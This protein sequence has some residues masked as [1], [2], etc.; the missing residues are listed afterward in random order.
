[1]FYPAIIPITLRND[2]QL[3]TKV[4]LALKS[5]KFFKKVALVKILVILFSSSSA[6]KV[7]FKVLWRLGLKE[8]RYTMRDMLRLGCGVVP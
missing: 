1:V 7:S 2:W 5:E 8:V 6:I 3:S 4:V